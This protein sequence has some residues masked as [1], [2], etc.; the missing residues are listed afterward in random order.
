MNK[1]AIYGIVTAVV[2][3]AGFVAIQPLQQA[4]AVHTTILSSTTQLRTVAATAF[5][6]PSPS[7]SKKIS[8]NA[9]FQVIQVFAVGDNPGLAADT[10][11]FGTTDFDGAGTTY[12]AIALPT[13]LDVDGGDI[14]G[15]GG[16]TVILG[17]LG[18]V[19]AGANGRVNVDFGEGNAADVDTTN[20][21]AVVLT[22]NQATCS[23]T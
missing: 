21:S 5:D 2:M 22:T 13:G 1:L 16:S 18:G 10:V 4:S 6:I 9:P 14:A 23:I 19:S 15:S 20:V 7:V 17:T 3:A 12:A 8:C 11:A